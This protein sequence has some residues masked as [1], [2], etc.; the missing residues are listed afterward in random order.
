MLIL[1]PTDYCHGQMTMS[2][3]TRTLLC[4]TLKTQAKVLVMLEWLCM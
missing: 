2:V 4:S 1:V 3:E